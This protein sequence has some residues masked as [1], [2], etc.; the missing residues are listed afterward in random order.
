[1]NDLQPNILHI[2]IR[3]NVVQK[4]AMRS[5]VSTPLVPC[6]TRAQGSRLSLISHPRSRT[7]QGNIQTYVHSR[8]YTT[9]YYVP[10]FPQVF[11]RTRRTTQTSLHSLRCYSCVRSSI[12]SK[13]RADFFMTTWIAAEKAKAAIRHSVVCPNMT[14]R[15]KEREAQSTRALAGL[16]A[17]VE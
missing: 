14:E 6:T 11:S 10:L 15:T 16:L 7:H 1:M 13:K 8:K 2:R 4:Q 12:N 17:A 5:S 9:M 3:H